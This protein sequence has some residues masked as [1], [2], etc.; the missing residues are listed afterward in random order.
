MNIHLPDLHP[1]PYPAVNAVLQELLSGVQAILGERLVGLYLYGS[2]AG[3]DFDPRTSDI[4]FVAVTSR[5]LPEDVFLALKAL[6][7]RLAAGPSK[8]G[9]ELEG[10]YIPQDALR[11]YDPAHARYPHIERGEKLVVEQQD[12]DGVIQRH[13]LREQG[14]VLVGPAP[15]TLVDPISPADLRQAVRTLFLWWWAPMVHDPA[16]LHHVGYHTYAIL[17]MCRILYTLQYGS[18]VSKPV[19]ARWALAALDGRWAP[20]I[21]RA[22]AWQVKEDDLDETRAW[23]E[24]TSQAAGRRL[25][26]TD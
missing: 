26:G 18:I 6:H 25:A 12:C 8:W 20:L 21:E 2:L 16:R 23:I 1:T 9:A 14:I 11:R 5:E 10:C 15:A 19:A 4:D 3:G 22:L 17:T 7:E 13:I 24:Y